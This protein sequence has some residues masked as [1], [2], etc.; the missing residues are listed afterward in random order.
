MWSEP[1]RSENG[2]GETRAV[3]DHLGRVSR[4]PVEVRRI[5]SLCPSLTET[6]FALGV[7]RRV[8]GRTRYC[9]HPEEGVKT[10]CKVGGTKQVDLDAVRVLRPDVVVAAREEN[11]REDVEAI[12]RS[13]PVFVTDV[14]TYE[15]GVDVIGDLAA[16]VGMRSA[17][18]RLMGRVREAF[19]PL[20]ASAADGRS[21]RV[22]Y[23]IWRAPWMG[24]GGGTYIGDLLRLCGFGNA[25]EGAESRYP[26]V[27]LDGLGEM[28]LDA[29][30]LSSEPFPFVAEHVA[31]VG[32]A[33]PGVDV[34]LVDG[35]MFGWYGVRMEQAG[36]YLA[37]L[38][39]AVCAGA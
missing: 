22:A 14:E 4:V 24:V 12:A 23:L 19:G 28:G 32:E 20:M 10:V 6:L 5:V 37:R 18:E 15:A 3:R 13:C 31:E 1:G 8:V 38:R 30:F 21:L 7:G 11:R 27:T 35:E 36:G 9:V 16:L 26:E 39:E 33:L 25:L 2:G 17:G 29:V 34:R